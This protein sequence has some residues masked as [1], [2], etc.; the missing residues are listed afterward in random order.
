[1]KSDRIGTTLTRKENKYL[2]LQFQ[3]FFNKSYNKD[4]ILV[5]FSLT[6]EEQLGIW[7]LFFESLNYTLL[8]T[9]N[10]YAI[11][12]CKYDINPQ[13]L[14]ATERRMKETGTSFL[15]TAYDLN[16]NSIIEVYEL[17]ILDLII[18]TKGGLPF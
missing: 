4:K 8:V 16:I 11:D 3:T 15:K 1:M 6:L 2:L 17:A 10:S 13:T 9:P 5:F 7:L 18:I 14:D 12:H